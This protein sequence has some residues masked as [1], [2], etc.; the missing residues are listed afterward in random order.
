M[1]VLETEYF[2]LICR[3]WMLE[4]ISGHSDFGNSYLHDRC[5]MYVYGI[6]VKFLLIVLLLH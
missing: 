2:G 5:C 3:V 4:K 1:I 6:T